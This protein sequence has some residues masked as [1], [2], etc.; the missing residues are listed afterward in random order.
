MITYQL[1]HG[2]SSIHPAAQFQSVPPP[3]KEPTK[4]ARRLLLLLL[5][6]LLDGELLARGILVLA[7]DGLRNHLVLGL[8]G[9]VLVGLRA[10]LEDILLDPVDA[11]GILLA[12]TGAQQY[13]G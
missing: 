8:L 7:A 12:G 4:P 6:L 10:L 2:S 3:L 13:F 1:H 5:L 9:R 11:C